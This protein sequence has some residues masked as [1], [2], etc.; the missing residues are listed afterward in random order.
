[1]VLDEWYAVAT[2]CVL[3]SNEEWLTVAGDELISFF[4]DGDAILG[5]DGD[6]TV[7]GSFTNTHEGSRKV[8]KLIGR[9]GSVR[10]M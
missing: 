9:C 4:V 10:E 8:V 2:V 7:V 6:G 3:T 1:M 5:E